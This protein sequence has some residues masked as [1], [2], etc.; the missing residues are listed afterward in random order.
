MACFS[1]VTLQPTGYPHV[2][3]FTEIR[4]L[5]FYSLCE[6]GHD[7]VLATNRF[8]EGAT[9]IVFGAHL[10]SEDFPVELPAS[11]LIFNTEQLMEDGSV[12]SK[13]IVGFAHQHR[14][15][16]YTSA[17]L[18]RLRNANPVARVHRVRLGYHR[19]LERVPSPR[20][21]KEGFLFYGS[22]TPMREKILARIKLSNRLHV[23]AFFGVYG[24]QR[25]GL[26][27]RC[28]AVLNLHAHPARL[29]E[30]PRILHLVANAIPCIALL[31]PETVAEDNQLSY[32]LPSDEGSPTADLER[33]FEVPEQLSTHAQLARERFRDEEPQHLF[34]ASLLDQSFASGFVPAFGPVKKSGWV[35][36]PVQRDPDP[37][38]Y[39]HTY[40][41]ICDPRSVVDFHRQEGML[42]QLHPDPSF[43][44]AFRSPL[45]LSPGVSIAASH[46]MRC[47]VVLH[48]HSEHKA[49]LFFASFGCHLAGVADFFATTSSTFVSATLKSLARDYGV[50]MEVCVIDNRG[51]DIPS[52][53]IVF[54]EAIQSYDLCLFSHGKESD[55][56]WF[57]DH[58]FLLA[59]SFERVNGILDLFAA[60][61]DLGLL[62]PDYLPAMLPYIG[63]GTM[64]SQVDQLLELFG[65]NTE[66][67]ELLEFPAGGF[68]WARPKALELLHSLGLTFDDL[69]QEP[70]SVDG[71]ILHALER[72]PCL[73]CE[74]MG[75]RWEKISR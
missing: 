48:M 67:I 44:Q 13:R 32:V 58:N 54:N 30:W 46:R 19:E 16:D 28:R 50:S 24:W 69:P 49:R 18:R 41:W 10:I 20:N 29:L 6:L 52:K 55:G 57:H 7:V 51:R 64:R 45:Q 23:Q 25:D 62:F 60:E 36:C 47:A 63:W 1:L 14:I 11:A 38:W 39:V 40:Y 2:A 53:Y 72:M 33:W 3:A 9:P 74:V 26:L 68:F 65:F 34:T 73:S 8:P 31:H 43:I 22:I 70:L 66:P 59:G 75:M 42:R 37:L 21:D 61:S 15:W 12:W 4:L 5:L 56:Q 35:P 17:N 27:S 71:T